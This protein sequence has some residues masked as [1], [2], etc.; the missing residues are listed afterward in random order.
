MSQLGLGDYRVT[1]LQTGGMEFER[2]GHLPDR[3]AT[4]KLHYV[5]N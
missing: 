4:T 3:K 2:L 5:E 1:V